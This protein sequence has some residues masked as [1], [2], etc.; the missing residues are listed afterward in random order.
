MQAFDYLTEYYT[1]YSPEPGQAI[2][3]ITGLPN[4]VVISLAY[5]I[6]HL[7]AFG[8]ADAF[9]APQFFSPFAAKSHMLL[10][11]NTLTNL[12]VKRFPCH[13]LLSHAKNL[14][15]EILRNAT[16]GTLK[17]SLL[18]I[19]DHTYTNFGSRL[20]QNWVSKPLTDKRYVSL[21]IIL[22]MSRTSFVEVSCRSVS[23]LSMRF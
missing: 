4:Q 11:G 3:L 21:T 15:R 23:T 22:A 2:A 13:S 16:D 17:G 6:R 19:L 14:C 10:D 12:S 7:V 18:W 5:A 20:L 9:L 1:K 8:I